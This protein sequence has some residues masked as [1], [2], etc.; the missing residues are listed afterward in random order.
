MKLQ[1][2]LKDI[3]VERDMTQKQ[4]AELADVSESTVSSLCNGRVY[5]FSSDVALKICQA[6]SLGS[7]DDLFEVVDGD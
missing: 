7:I 1:S 2:K 6:L 4:L 3:L 5:A